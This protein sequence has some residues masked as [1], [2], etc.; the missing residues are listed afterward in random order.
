MEID[1]QHKRVFIIIPVF[2]EKTVI[3]R[4]IEEIL[5][6]GCNVIVVDDGSEQDIYIELKDLHAVEY[7]RHK[8]NLG[9]G[10]ALQTG[11]D[12]ALTRGGDYFVTFDADGQHRG[13]DIPMML[14]PLINNEADIALAS[15]FLVKGSHN[16]S[17]VR[18]IL[19]QVG[20]WVNFLFTG[21][22]LSDSHNGFRA[23]N[24]I[25]AL[26]IRITENRMAHATEIIAQI[27]KHQLRYIEVPSTVT[28]TD[29]SRGKGQSG[30][31]SVRIFFDL[32]LQK[33]F[34]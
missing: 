31:Q 16:A 14:R 21:L 5:P 13:G 10:A 27:K 4:V 17:S 9:Q 12:L 7:I 24:R 25:A 6:L 26:S 34:K 20:R 30:I 33:L 15:R 28:Y 22:Y 3:R 32:V 11:I 2:N 29:Y 23:L 8:A 18:R 19:L 1:L